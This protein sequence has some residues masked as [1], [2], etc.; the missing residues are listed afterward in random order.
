[1]VL[2][3][4]KSSTLSNQSVVFATKM[5]D[6]YDILTARG[7]HSNALSNKMLIWSTEKSS[8]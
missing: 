3:I 8:V 7:Q 6:T 4:S 2:D 1:M 5:C